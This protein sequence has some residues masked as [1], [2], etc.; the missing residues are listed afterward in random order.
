MHFVF[1]P[2][3]YILGK[4]DSICT[5]EKIKKRLEFAVLTEVFFMVF[6]DGVWV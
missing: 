1:N 2:L 5:N 6:R 4:D 3:L